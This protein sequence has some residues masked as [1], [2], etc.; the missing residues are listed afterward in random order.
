M[1]MESVQQ[2]ILGR[3]E[4]LEARQLNPQMCGSTTRSSARASSGLPYTNPSPSPQYL[5]TQTHQGACSYVGTSGSFPPYVPSD[6][7]YQ[8]HLD[9]SE[10]TATDPYEVGGASISPS[11]VRIHLRPN[12]T[13]ALPS[14]EIAKHTLR[15]VRDVLEENVKL[16]TESSAA[17]L[18]QKLAKEAFFGK[19]VM[20]RCT[21]GGNRQYPALPQKELFELKK[22]MFLLFP[23]FHTCP[24]AFEAVWK[25][26]RLRLNK[27]VSAWAFYRTVL[28]ISSLTV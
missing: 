17:T 2:Q 8:P 19:A 1:R 20:K 26:V 24:G 3:L 15:N 22:V 13:A 6:P 11:P 23:R 9:N 7:L 27:L 16:Q 10:L 25:N 14:S 12:A 4:A 21:P 5:S 18:S 28:P